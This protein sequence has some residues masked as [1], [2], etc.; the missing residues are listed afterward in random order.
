MNY[1]KFPRLATALAA[2]LLLS[3]CGSDLSVERVAM[4]QSGGDTSSQTVDALHQTIN[5]HRR[6]IGKAALTRH[7]GLDQLAY[8]HCKFM[9]NNRGKFTLGSQNIS[10]YGFEERALMAKRAYRLESLSEN[11][12]GGKISGDIPATLLTSWNNSSK[13]RYNLSQD[14]DAT[15]LGVYVADDGMVYATQLFAIRNRSHMALTDRMTSF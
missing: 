10:H 13:H 8:Q 12:A 6:S 1:L 4:A 14:W 3:S 15:G 7:S 9:A 5:S 2:A 11:V